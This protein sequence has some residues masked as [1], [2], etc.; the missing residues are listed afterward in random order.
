MNTS[1]RKE[2]YISSTNS[3]RKKFRKLFVLS[4][5][6]CEKCGEVHNFLRPMAHMRTFEHMFQTRTNGMRLN[7]SN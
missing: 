4:K 2:V 5:V 7:D 1:L 6:I 3:I